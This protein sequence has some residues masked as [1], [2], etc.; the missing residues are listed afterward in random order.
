M[1]GYALKRGRFMGM[2]GSPC[3]D[4]RKKNDKKK[5]K[6]DRLMGA[7]DWKNLER[8]SRF[9]KKERQVKKIIKR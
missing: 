2:H 9:R 8:V 3:A 4:E 7:T 5:K 6:W 1:H